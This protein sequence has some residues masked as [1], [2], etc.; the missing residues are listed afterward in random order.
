LA[1]RLLD[2]GGEPFWID[3]AATWRFASVPLVDLFRAIAPHETNP[4]FFFALQH[5]VLW[6]GESEAV[7]RLLPL[8][9]GVAT[10]LATIVIGTTAFGP[11][12]GR[13]AGLLV[14][15][16]AMHVAYS[17][18]ARAYT[19]VTLGAAVALLGLL[20]LLRAAGRDRGGAALY[21]VGTTIALLGHNTAVFLPACATLFAG[22]W[23]LR[24]D[25][26]SLRLPLLW[27][28]ANLPPLLVLLAWWPVVLGQIGAANIAWIEQ[29]SPSRALAM[30][31]N[32]YGGLAVRTAPAYLLA[33]GGVLGA[34][35]LGGLL[36]HRRAAAAWL[37][38]GFAA[39]VPL[40]TWLVGLV[41]QPI[42]IGRT[43]LWAS[44]PFLVLVAAGLAALRGWTRWLALCA[45]AGP[46]LLHLAWYYDVD[47]LL[48]VGVLSLIHI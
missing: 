35:A 20:R 41:V 23:W 24:F 17:Q 5:F 11:L 42:M 48:A 25:R 14:T 43:L 4:P 21:A 10:V 18:E 9:L 2:L 46:M 40:L 32:V 33:W 6:L 1:L 13:L 19:L 12:E 28:V 16:S 29:P 47:R 30:T 34:L 8:A 27:I 36:R 37:L 31:L 39:L 26:R 7:L 44:L 15:L 3:E 22:I 38:L 45:V